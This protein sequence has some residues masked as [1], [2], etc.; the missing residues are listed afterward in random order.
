[1]EIKKLSQF[2]LDDI[3]NSF[4][5]AFE[6]YV[7][8]LD[9]NKETTLQRWELAGLDFKKSYGVIDENKIVAFIFQLNCKNHL[10]NFGT[11]VVPSHRGK[12]LIETL[13][14][15]IEKDVQ[16]PVKFSLEVIRENLKAINLYKKLNFQVKR[17]LISFRGKLI[18]GTEI[19]KKFQ[20]EIK[21]LQYTDE[22]NSI[23]LA[24]PSFEN[25]SCTTLIHPHMHE[26]HELRSNG[27]LLAYA[28]FTPQN[29]SLREIGS[30]P[31]FDENLDQLFLHMKLNE[32]HLRFMNID[33]NAK[34]LIDYI[35]THGMS[36]FVTQYEM[37]KLFFTS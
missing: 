17:E 35:H 2:S 34:E 32:E 12:H 15:E 10:Y 26:V 5:E 27:I 24:K 36:S 33:E 28:V 4:K 3:Y 13:Y 9:F 7:I 21:P 37:E 19:S 25:S 1:M 23:S 29:L 30:L 6:N 14:Q 16:A 22:M 18:I 8:P 31:D 20:Y 11:G